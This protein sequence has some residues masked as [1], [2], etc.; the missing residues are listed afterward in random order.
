MWLGALPEQLTDLTGLTAIKLSGFRLE[1]SP[2]P[3]LCSV[4]SLQTITLQASQSW[5]SWQ[6]DTFRNLA[7][8]SSITSLS[9]VIADDM[10]G[11]EAFLYVLPGITQLAALRHL[12]ISGYELLD[13]DVLQLEEATDLQKLP[14]DMVNMTGLESLNLSR[15]GLNCL[16]SVVTDLS[17]LTELRL[18]SN[19]LS[20]L[21]FRQNPPA[22]SSTLRVLDVSGQYGGMADSIPSWICSFTKLQELVLHSKSLE[23][24]EYAAHDRVSLLQ[25]VSVL[26]ELKLLRI[27]DDAWQRPAV[28][29]LVAV[30]QHLARSGRNL[31]I[32]LES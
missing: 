30:M 12:D 14:K 2:F 27:H 1:Q 23:S 17:A 13:F 7:D 10:S 3:L 8:N 21:A 18:A 26:P 32:D 22:F 20:L 25:L 4:P 29:T 11:R 19:S 5:Q 9:L 31:V 24:S 6:L 15:C 28:A 16:P